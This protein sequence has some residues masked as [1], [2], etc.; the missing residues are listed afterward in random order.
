MGTASNKNPSQGTKKL[1]HRRSKNRYVASHKDTYCLDM[2]KKS[3]WKFPPFWKSSEH[4]GLIALNGSS[5]LLFG[6]GGRKSWYKWVGQ[7]FTSVCVEV[8]YWAE[9]Y[10]GGESTTTTLLI[11]CPSPQVW[12]A[13]T[14][15]L[16]FSGAKE[17]GC[18]FSI[19]PLLRLH[20]V[21]IA[22]AFW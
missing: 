2:L 7:T 5:T 16:A 3:A 22:K 20:L 6:E 15:K 9:S 8:A 10:G 1:W 13:C 17:V 12:W 14:H 11:H 21:C 19:T 18:S 4:F